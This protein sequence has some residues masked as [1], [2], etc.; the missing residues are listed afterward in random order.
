MKKWRLLK[1]GEVDG[2]E[3]NASIESIGVAKSKGLT[4]NTLA[5]FRASTFVWVGKEANLSQVNVSFCNDNG[6]PI[7][8]S[9][10]GRG[11]ALI[12]H[13]SQVEYTLLADRTFLPSRGAA[14][15]RFIKCVVK[16]CQILGLPAKRR[17]GSNDVLVGERKI[18]GMGIINFKNVL[19]FNGTFLLDWDSDLSQ[20][21]LTIPTE[22]FADK[23]A[24][25]VEQWLTTAKRELN[26]D[27]SLEEAEATLIQGFGEVLQVDFDVT[28]SLTEAEKQ[29]FIELLP[30]YRSET[31]L[32]GGRWSPVKDYGR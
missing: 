5:F 12:S 26:R 21:V 3:L 14:Y 27:V 11:V 13:G 4:D 18:A 20:K 29:I 15:G 23:K 2:Y 10:V 22:K 1:L 19:M 7:V 25:S 31:W 30:K 32:K 28:T 6:I 24:K 17:L 9:L 8:R 16:S